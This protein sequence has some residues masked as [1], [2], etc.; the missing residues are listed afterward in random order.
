MKTLHTT[1]RN[2]ANTHGRIRAI[3]AI[4]GILIAVLCSIALL[5]DMHAT[6]ALNAN[7]P[8]LRKTSGIVVSD[9]VG[10]VMTPAVARP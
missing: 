9:F 5:Q 3:L 1:T 4:V 8:R 6:E 10:K 2:V 7:V